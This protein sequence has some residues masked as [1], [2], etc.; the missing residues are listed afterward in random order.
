MKR[1]KMKSVGLQ[2]GPYAGKK[3]TIAAG[4]IRTFNFF[5]GYY[6]SSFGDVTSPCWKWVENAI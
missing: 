4:A 5:G 6:T 1:C 2:N 3:L